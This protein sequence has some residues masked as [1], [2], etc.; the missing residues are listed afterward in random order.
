MKIKQLQ[1]IIKNKELTLH[2]FE[3]EN[4]FRTLKFN[5]I[6]AIFN[7]KWSCLNKNKM[8]KI[9]LIAFTRKLFG[10]RGITPEMQREIMPYIA[11]IV[12]K[13]I[14]FIKVIFDN[15]KNLVFDTLDINTIDILYDINDII[16]KNQYNISKENMKDK[17]VVDCGANKGVFSLFAVFLGA[18]RV[19]SFEPVSLSY[20]NMGKSINLNKAEEKIFTFKKALGENKYKD[21]VSFRYTGDGG[22]RI[23]NEFQSK[24]DWKNEPVEVI[25]LDDCKLGKIDFIKIDTEGF[26]ANVLRGAMKKIKKY[27]PILSFSAYHKPEDKKEL[28]ELVNSIR[29]D[30]KIELNK[31]S[32]EVFYC[33]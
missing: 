25:R 15:N 6:K 18:K 26:E 17:V 16:Y 23:D 5:Y 20:A 21:I 3:V 11:N 2:G 13:D 14:L 7:D 30:Y 12:D 8:I 32:E 27:K 28:P 4:L 22:G 24:K 1:F 19:Y 10:K 9:L 29:L 31:F 33:S